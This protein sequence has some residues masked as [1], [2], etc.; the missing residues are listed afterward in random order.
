[1]QQMCQKAAGSVG[2]M[3]LAR[4]RYPGPA[5]R[6]ADGN[7]AAILCH[8]PSNLGLIENMPPAKGLWHRQRRSRVPRSEKHRAGWLP[9]LFR[10]S[11]I[12]ASLGE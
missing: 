1:M 8:A 4:R 9:S 10:W 2:W 7:A 5:L 12:L 6:A 11:K 3:K